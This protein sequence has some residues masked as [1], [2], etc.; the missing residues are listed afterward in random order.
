MITDAQISAY[1]IEYAPEDGGRWRRCR[2]HN[3]E[4]NR[5]FHFVTRSRF[6]RLVRHDELTAN[7]LNEREPVVIQLRP[8]EN[9]SPIRYTPPIPERFTTSNVILFRRRFR[10]RNMVLRNSVYSRSGFN[11]DRIMNH[12]ML[13]P[14][15]E[16]ERSVVLNSI[17]AAVH[18]RDEHLVM[19]RPRIYPGRTIEYQVMPHVVN[20]VEQPGSADPVAAQ[21]LDGIPDNQIDEDINAA[22]Q[23]DEN[24]N[25]IATQQ[26]EDDNPG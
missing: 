12:Y 2:D 15:D 8:F 14:Q 23:I 16:D 1:L 25:R 21:R 5:R 17:V 11:I 3:N 9:G 24:I 20:Q 4:F 13:D 10:I 26:I 22:Q 18:Y 7:L 19:N 6:Y